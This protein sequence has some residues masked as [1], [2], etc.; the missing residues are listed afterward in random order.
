MNF[1]TKQTGLP[2]LTTDYL[3]DDHVLVDNVFADLWH[4]FGMK[5]LIS[6][7]G[8]RKR[9]GTSV[10]T[11][12]YC[13]IMWVWLKSNSIRMFS[14]DAMQSFC[15]AK[16][17]AL[18]DLMNREDLNWRKLNID[19]ACKAVKDHQIK[20]DK[21]LVLDDSIKQRYGKK[22]PGVSSHFDHTTGRC[23]MGQQVLTLGLS[24][25]KGFFPVDSE[26]FI[27]AS[28]AQGLKSAFKDGRSHVAQRYRAAQQKTKPKMAEEMI[29]RALKAGLDADYLLADAWFGTKPMIRIAEEALVTPILRMKK[30]KMK[31]RLTIFQNGHEVSKEYD[32][33]ELYRYA[34]RGQWQKTPGQP[35][36]SKALDV[37]LNL[38][39]SDKEPEQW[40]K[41]RLLFVRGSAEQ[42]EETVGK[43]QW[44]LFLT[45][46]VSMPP[47]R[48]LV[49]YA[50]RWA[51]EVYFKEAKQHLGFLKEQGTH[52]AAYV[53]SIHLAAIRFCMLMSAMMTDESRRLCSIRADL[54]DNLQSISFATR[55]WATFRML[56]TGALEELR[57]VFGDDVD[58]IIATI[59]IHVQSFFMQALQLDPLVLS[60]EST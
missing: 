20:G 41:V 51:I 53:A 35:Y 25:E 57:T 42:R 12:I 31:Y 33:K 3:K 46:D 10:D 36:L 15:F 21:A 29:N 24:T 23:M 44:A 22:M 49:L 32:A 34:I 59:D 16:K 9:S 40:T 14:T 1:D 38:A 54:S 6:K 30:N 52:Y 56:I 55:L 28:K 45:T 19:A 48:I 26:L 47:K 7:A 8:I 60:L 43:H 18:Y 11:L 2:A 37:E 50:M 58:K 5:G 4:T 17:D 27:S 39:S 13:L